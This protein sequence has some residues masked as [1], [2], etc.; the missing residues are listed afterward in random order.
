MVVERKVDF[1]WCENR[2]GT[3]SIVSEIVYLSVTIDKNGRCRKE[4][5]NS[6]AQG[7]R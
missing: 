2:L 6:G 1:N 3:L 7:K 4:M 5:E